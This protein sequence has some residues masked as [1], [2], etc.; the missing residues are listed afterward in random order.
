MT[1][2]FN[3][4]KNYLNNPDSKNEDSPWDKVI[5]FIVSF[6]ITFIIKYLLSQNKNDIGSIIIDT[7]KFAIANFISKLIIGLIFMFLIYPNVKDCGDNENSCRFNFFLN[8]LFIQIIE[9]LLYSSLFAIFLIVNK[10][11][12]S[13]GNPDKPFNLDNL[14]NLILQQ[15]LTHRMMS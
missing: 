9:P 2:N 4:F 12:D 8:P 7:I 13:I 3:S 5:E 15:L 1:N 11:I 10:Y 6:I 14:T